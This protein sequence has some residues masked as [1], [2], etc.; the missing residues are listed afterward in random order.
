MFIASFVI[1]AKSE[2]NPNAHQLVSEQIKY[3]TSIQWNT[4]WQ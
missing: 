4:I 3:F 1:I 2:N